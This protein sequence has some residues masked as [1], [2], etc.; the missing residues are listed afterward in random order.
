MKILGLLALIATLLIRP[1][2]AL[3]QPRAEDVYADVKEIIE[4]LMVKEVSESVIVQVACY[5]PKG[6]VRYY[7]RTLQMIWER[8]FGVVRDVML[9]EA[10]EL[11]GNYTYVSLLEGRPVKLSDFLPAST[12]GCDD[13]EALRAEL[14]ELGGPERFFAQL[15]R[16]EKWSCPTL[17]L[18]GCHGK[19][20]KE[21][22]PRQAFAC[23][24]ATAAMHAARN[25]Q[26]LVVEYVS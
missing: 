1:N 6:L 14:K 26:S 3:A 20:P 16:R 4:D 19:P 18:D 23:N 24:A 8:N 12:D 15:Q 10:I 22:N 25:N 7:P 11:L 2:A 9:D 17:P 5:S 13:I 21:H